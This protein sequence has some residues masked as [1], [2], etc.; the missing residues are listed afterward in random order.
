MFLFIIL[1]GLLILHYNSAY[2]AVKLP[3]IRN[4]K[5]ML[6]SD[7]S[8]KQS[9]ESF[10]RQQDCDEDIAKTLLHLSQSFVS[11][12]RFIA[13]APILGITGKSNTKNSFEEDQK[14]LDIISNDIIK[15]ELRSSQ[16]VKIIATEE[17]DEP[18]VLNSTLKSGLVVVYDPLD[19]S[20]NIDCAIPTGTI[21]G[22]YRTLSDSS[23]SSKNVLQ[24]GNGLV[25]AGY[26]MYSS[27][28]E[29]VLSTGKGTYG[30]TMHPIT[31]EFFLTRSAWKCP[32][33]G[34]Y[35]SLNEG[36]ASDWPEGL[37]RYISD[38]KD[39]HSAWGKRYSSRYVCSLVADVHRSLLYGGW[40]GNPRSHLRYLYEAAPLAFIAEQCGGAGSDGVQRIL[41]ITPTTLHH[42]LPVF[43]GS[44]EDIAELESYGDVQQLG[45]KKYEA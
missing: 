19:G 20:S 1:L 43:I 6:A 2:Y 12:A 16:Y 35:Y 44:K 18:I 28:I 3:S 5:V 34:P 7:D 9:L 15:T 21:F 40:A 39:G 8:Y 22:I 38:I 13:T 14:K 10:L 30:F 32:S 42:R 4:V 31:R 11:I 41:D 29:Y 25:A 27:S 24:S 37:R 33:R 23:D 36:R 45:S 26:S 17:D